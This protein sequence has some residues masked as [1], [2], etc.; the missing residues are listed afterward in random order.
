VLEKRV[1]DGQ[2]AMA[3]DELYR[4]VDLT[5]V[6]VIAN[7]PEQDLGHVRIGDPATV[8]F[9]A[10]PGE[11][12]Q[13]RVTFIYYDMTPETRTAKIRIELANADGR[14]KPDMYGDVV[15]RA[16]ASEAPVIAIPDSALIDNGSR[17]VVLIARG[18]GRFEPRPVK[19]G[20]R[21]EGYVEVSEGVS[22]GEEVVT[23]AT[24]LIDAESNLR[25]A[26]KAFTAPEDSK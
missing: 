11:M 24:F 7:V 17:Q 2:R 25:A 10:Y 19:T 16:A 9:I 5:M 4:I 8:A 12:R 26:L 1:I 20:R 14:L 6:W 13:G 15:I 21:G 18:E 22:V 23:T 3:G